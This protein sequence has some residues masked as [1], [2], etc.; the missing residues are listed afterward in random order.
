MGLLR[1]KIDDPLDAFAVHFGGGF[2]GLFSAVIIARDAIVY[3]I[4][5]AIRGWDHNIGQAF[6]VSSIPSH[7]LEMEIFSANWLANDLHNSYYPLV[8]GVDVSNFYVFKQNWKISRTC[9][10]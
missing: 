4:W 9:R 10:D 7:P 6:A 3:Q 2:W 1:W 8:N 5:Y